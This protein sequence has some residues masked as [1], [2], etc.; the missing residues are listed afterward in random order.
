MGKRYV[1]YFMTVVF[2][3]ASV[4]DAFGRPPV[5]RVVPPAARRP[6]PR[7]VVPG[8]VVRAPIPRAVVGP[9]VRVGVGIGPIPR[10]AITGVIRP[11]PGVNGR[12]VVVQPSAVAVIEGQSIASDGSVVVALPENPAAGAPR[13][14]AK[15]DVQT[16]GTVIVNPSE[17]SA[18]LTYLLIDQQYQ[19]EASQLHEFELPEGTDVEI[20]F[21]RGAAQGTAR[22]KVKDKMIYTF[23]P[24]A[25]GWE[26]FG[27][28]AQ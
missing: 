5:R 23:W 1:W 27:N 24:T 13:K 21:D 22:Y 16:E 17:N 25:N 11:L 12:T 2:V 19:V 10:I 8:P 26:L 4:T 9:S 6:V 14:F 3:V 7:V 20:Q 15:P 18:T 28:S